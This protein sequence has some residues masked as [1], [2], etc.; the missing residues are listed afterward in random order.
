MNYYK[1]KIE[2]EVDI[3]GYTLFNKR[4]LYVEAK[5]MIAAIGIIEDI[6]S[7]KESIIYVKKVYELPRNTQIFIKENV[8]ND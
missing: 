1:I 4:K 2:K 8:K 6:L 5:S 7:K 3:Y